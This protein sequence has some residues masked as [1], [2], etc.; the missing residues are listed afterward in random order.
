[1]LVVG[2][3]SVTIVD[4]VSATVDKIESD[5]WKS[6]IKATTDNPWVH[7]DCCGEMVV[8]KCENN[9]IKHTFKLCRQEISRDGKKNR[10]RV[11]G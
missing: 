6:V 10:M 2:D 4:L 1:M 5:I 3:L 8:V 11:L 7:I 9:V